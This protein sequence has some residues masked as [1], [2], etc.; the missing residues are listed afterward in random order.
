ML[1]AFSTQDNERG[2]EDNKKHGNGSGIKLMI[3]HEVS[4]FGF[5]KRVSCFAHSLQLVVDKFK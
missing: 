1:R 2:E 3:E 5:I 4:F